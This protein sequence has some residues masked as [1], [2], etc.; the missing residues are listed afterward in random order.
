MANDPR[1]GEGWNFIDSDSEAWYDGLESE[2]AENGSEQV[3]VSKYDEFDDVQDLVN[4]VAGEGDYSDRRSFTPG[5]ED[6]EMK[7]RE[8]MNDRWEVPAKLDQI[9]DYL[10]E[11]PDISRSDIDLDPSAETEWVVTETEANLQ[12]RDTK[13]TAHFAAYDDSESGQNDAQFYISTS[14]YDTPPEEMTLEDLF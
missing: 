8:M 11:S 5:D 2:E 10:E 6:L 13:Y 1:K 14:W 4:F 9:K 12:D 7:K 3:D